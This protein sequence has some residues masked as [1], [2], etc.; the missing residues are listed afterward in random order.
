MSLN[1]LVDSRDVRFVLFEMLGI[2]KLGRYDRFSGLDKDVL[3]ETLNLAE[4]I[5]VEQFY[6]SNAEGDKTGLKYNPQTHEVTVPAS[7]HKGYNAF[8]DAG[9]HLLAFKPEEGGMGLPAV[10]SIAS[11][12]YFNAG[13]TSLAMYCSSLRGTAHLLMTFGSEEVKRMFIPRMLEGKWGGTMCL[14]EPGAGSDVGALKA[15]AVRQ[16]D[17]TYLI[18]GAENFYQ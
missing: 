15:K 14:T 1:S 4:Q 7:F 10:T 11:Q 13:N 8:I 6:P 2:D 3:D 12:E 16:A 5:A 18:T 17:G 9:F